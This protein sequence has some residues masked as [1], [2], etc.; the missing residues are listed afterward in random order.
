[1][2]RT[3]QTELGSSVSKVRSLA[4]TLAEEIRKKKYA[5]GT[6]LPSINCLSRRYGVSR[7][8]VFKAFAELRSR[9]LIA[10]APGKGYYVNATQRTIFLLLDEYS[11]FKDTLYNSFVQHLPSAHYKVDLWF[12][13]Y[14]EEI[15]SQVLSAAIG[16]Y[17]YY[18][19]MNFDN[20]RLSPLVSRLP[21]SRLLLLDFGRFDKQPYAYLCQNF[22][23]SFYEALETLTER[24]LSYR[25]IIFQLPAHSHHPRVSAEALLRYASAHGLSAEVSTEETIE[26]AREKTLYVVIRQIDVVSLIKAGRRSGLHCGADYGLI[27]YNDTPAYEVIG[28]G[29]TAMTIDWAEMGRRAARFITHDEVPRDYLPTIVRL[30]GS[31]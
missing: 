21:A 18:V 22:D 15:F 30:R 10:S 20:E 11:P 28:Q 14:N 29:I 3:E 9:K 25:R 16:R 17:D 26:Q 31:L 7:D 12:H 6:P 5:V 24:I 1:M 4:D 8:T 2:K 23:E 19:V 13:Q 27:A